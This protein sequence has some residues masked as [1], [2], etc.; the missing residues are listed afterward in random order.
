MRIGNYCSSSFSIEN[1]LKQGDNL[2]LQLFNFALKYAIRK[3]QE[4]SLRL[5]MDGTHQLLAFA[6]DINLIED[7]I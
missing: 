2:S 1:V 3:V 7:D 4:T 6:E 5:D